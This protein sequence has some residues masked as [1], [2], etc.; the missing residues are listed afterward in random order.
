MK[1]WKKGPMSKDKCFGSTG[2]SYLKNCQTTEE[3][4]ERQRMLPLITANPS[5]SY[6][7]PKSKVR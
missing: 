2:G 6:Y 4:D 3:R 5:S 7:K 1:S